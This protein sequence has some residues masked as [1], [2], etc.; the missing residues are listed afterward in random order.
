MSNPGMLLFMQMIH[1]AK[2]RLW[3]STPYFVPDEALQQGLE[4]AVLRGVDVRILIPRKA[5]YRLVHW[6]SLSYAEQVQ[7]TGVRIFLYDKGFVHQKVALV[8]DDAAFIGTSNF[9]NR[10]LYL[11]FELM[12]GVF[13]REFNREVEQMLLGDFSDSH[14]FAPYQDRLIR[15]LI[16]LRANGARLLAPLL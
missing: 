11:N 15:R 8:D 10:T 13:S 14:E 1:G 12:V 2:K 4:L 6:V 7:R 5:E 16:R 3:V 9:D